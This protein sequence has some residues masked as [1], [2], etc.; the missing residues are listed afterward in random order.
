ML[1]SIETAL[2]LSEIREQL[3]DLNAVTDPTEAQQTEERDLLASRKTT[4]VEYREA[5][6]AE[7]DEHATV[8]VNGEDREYRALLGRGNVGRILAAFVEHRSVDGAEAELQQHHGPGVESDPARLAARAG[9]AS[10]R[11]D[12]TH[13]RRHD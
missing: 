12:R 8:P 13:E 6:T 11:H 10:R 9:R 2:K 4:E 5:L 1:K 3:N 7:A